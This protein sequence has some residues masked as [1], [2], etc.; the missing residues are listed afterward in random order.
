[1]LKQLLPV[2]VD[3]TRNPSRPSPERA[4][5][6]APVRSERDPSQ[7]GRSAQQSSCK[8]LEVCLRLPGC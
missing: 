2:E 3:I 7:A 6:A 1:M 5:E 8:K 4:R